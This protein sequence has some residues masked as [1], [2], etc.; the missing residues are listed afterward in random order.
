MQRTVTIAGN[1]RYAAP[2]SEG[3]HADR[4]MALALA[5]HANEK[6]VSRVWFRVI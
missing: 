2:R 5:L 1:V 4:F 3:S 6:F